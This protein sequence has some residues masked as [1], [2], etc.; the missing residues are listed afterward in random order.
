MIHRYFLIALFG[1]SLLLGIQAPNFADQYARRVDAHWQE[2]TA[3]LQPFKEI[4]DRF[5]GGDLMALIRHH[6]ASKDSTFRAEAEAIENMVAR[7]ARFAKE[8][9]ALQKGGF[10]Q[11]AAHILFLGD[12]ELA[13]ETYAMYS[14]E[15]R[16]D[17][18]A[19]GSGLF[20]ALAACLL[21]EILLLAGKRTL[22][23]GARP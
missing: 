14:P 20:A 19:I 22:G 1:A 21:I 12:R 3:N 17:R 23:L 18:K 15:L 2:V 11:Q 9:E 6:R 5:H 7:K 10:P 4:A 8:R 16:L 13:R